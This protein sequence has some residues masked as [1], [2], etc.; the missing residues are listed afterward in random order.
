MLIHLFVS[1]EVFLD[2]AENGNRPEQSDENQND[3]T[4]TLIIGK[5]PVPHRDFLPS[6]RNSPSG[7]PAA[8]C[9]SRFANSSSYLGPQRRILCRMMWDTSA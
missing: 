8:S 4:A 6:I 7:T 5:V 1:V 2:Q 3:P 9:C